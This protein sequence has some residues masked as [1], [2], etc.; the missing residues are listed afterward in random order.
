M[1]QLLNL[2]P[3]I[4]VLH[5]FFLS[6][7]YHW[8]DVIV[9][10]EQNIFYRSIYYSHGFPALIELRNKGRRLI[11]DNYPCNLSVLKRALGIIV[12]SQHTI[13]LAHQWYECFN[14]ISKFSLVNAP[15]LPKE[16]S[17]LS[18]KEIRKKLG[19]N[20]NDFLIC[21]FGFIGDTKQCHRSILACSTYYPK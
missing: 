16:I 2:Y 18:R 21:T 15:H 4:V 5:D 12:L 14:I 1:L 11:I 20:E 10:K 7:L 6:G 19:F 3:G 8:A 17:P 9:E 13:D